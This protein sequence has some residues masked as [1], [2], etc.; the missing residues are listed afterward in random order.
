MRNLSVNKPAV[1][2]KELFIPVLQHSVYVCVC[3]LHLLLRG[4]VFVLLISHTVAADHSLLNLAFC[5]A[6]H[7]MSSCISRLHVE[8]LYISY[9]ACFYRLRN[10]VSTKVV[11]MK[12]SFMKNIISRTVS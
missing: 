4:P 2:L 5:L 9:V 10:I 11:L 12:S 8:C 6:C 3:S 1:E 7:S